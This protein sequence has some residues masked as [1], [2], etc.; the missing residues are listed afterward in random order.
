[1][2]V[3]PTYGRLAAEKT[4]H[5]LNWLDFTRATIFYK[6]DFT[7]ETNFELQERQSRGL[8]KTYAEN[9]L[10][11]KIKHARKNEPG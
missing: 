9:W 8:A 11:Q 1:M 2:L 4:E 6:P 3:C 5:R 10:Y 7:N